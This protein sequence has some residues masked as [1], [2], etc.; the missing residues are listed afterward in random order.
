MYKFYEI[1]RDFGGDIMSTISHLRD[2]TLFAPSNAAF[3]EP[4]VQK[5]LQ[6]KERVKEMLNLHYVKDRLPI[7]KIKNKSVNQVSDFIFTNF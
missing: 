4:G 5:I 3:E 6:D 7:E 1:I 2:V